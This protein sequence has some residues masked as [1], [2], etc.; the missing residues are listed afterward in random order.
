MPQEKVSSSGQTDFLP[1]FKE[2]QSIS[3]SRAGDFYL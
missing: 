3:T 2:S 1:P